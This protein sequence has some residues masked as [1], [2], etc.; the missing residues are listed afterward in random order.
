MRTE[1][2]G[3]VGSGRP[4]S[5]G[6]AGTVL[7]AMLALPVALI[8]SGCAWS[9][10]VT[11]EG[12][13]LT[14]L[15][16]G[17]ATRSAAASEAAKL[18]ATLTRTYPMKS[19]STRFDIDRVL[20]DTREITRPGVRAGGS[21]EEREAAEYIVKRLE[22]MDLSPR[23]EV[24][25]LPN[26]RESRNVIVVLPG[27]DSR[28]VVVGAHMDSK[29]P[30]PGANDDAVG[31]AALLELAR[32]FKDR[33]VVPTVELVFFGTEE[34]IDSTPG[35]H[36]YGSRHRVASMSAAERKKV[37]GMMTLDL[38][39]VGPRLHARTMG[40]GTRSMANHLIAS[41][42]RVG[43][44]MTYLR[45]PGSSGWA[46]HEP[47]E[48][49]GIPAVWIERLPDPRYHTTGDTVAHLE[50]ERLRATLMVAEEAVR[51]LTPAKLK[52]LRR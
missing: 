10:R 36:H 38:L 49:A 30:S 51:S 24:F 35:H 39:A 52:A 17:E 9:S 7:L 48:K 20:A 44:S 18:P 26:G 15:A 19:A 11:A 31:C 3:A 21:A 2:C 47:Y 28:R 29:P 4:R 41:A 33:P 13:G 43:V 5:L 27:S 12:F 32:V 40:I 23:V 6:V 25:G 1:G 37:A 42:R 8:P 34:Y 45:D 46:D 16:Q 22:A 50:R 14:P